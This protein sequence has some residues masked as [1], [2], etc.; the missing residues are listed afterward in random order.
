MDYPAP[1]VR[2]DAAGE[3]D[4]SRAYATGAGD[5]DRHA[6]R[7]AY[8]EFAPG[9]DEAARLD[10]IARSGL[11]RGFYY[12]SDAEARPAGAAH[13]RANLWDNGDDAVTSLE[14]ALRVRRIALS[15]FGERNLGRGE[16]GRALPQALLEETLV[17]VYFHHRFQLNAAAKLVGGVEYRYTV[18]GD[19]GLDQARPVSPERQRRAIAAI[20]ETISPEALDLPEDLVRKILPRPSGYS[21]HRELFNGRTAPLFDPM[22]AAATMADLTVRAL[23]QPERAA[24]MIDQHRRNAAAPDFVELLEALVAKSFAETTL[25]EPRAA[26]LA[27]VVQRVV[28][29]RLL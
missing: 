20:L 21:P 12:L 22:S 14:N 15:R 28:V 24:R 17:P 6:I 19:G 10:E 16:G 5:W 13:P 2:V 8:T 23:L 18:I 3:L 29:D 7:W 11:E 4:V 9:E 27:R 26:E 1:L 25:L